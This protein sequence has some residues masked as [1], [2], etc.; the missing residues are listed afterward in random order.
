MDNKYLNISDKK[1]SSSWFEIMNN[2]DCDIIILL[3]LAIAGI[4]ILFLIYP[5]CESNVKNVSKN[6]ENMSTGDK[7][8]L[9]LITDK[10]S[11]AITT[12]LIESIVTP[13]MLADNLKTKIDKINCIA[14]YK[15]YYDQ[16]LKYPLADIFYYLGMLGDDPFEKDDKTK[17]FNQQYNAARKIADVFADVLSKQ[18]YKLYETYDNDGY[19]A[20]KFSKNMNDDL[21]IELNKIIN[22]IIENPNQ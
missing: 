22:K 13:C 8:T 21:S 5:R 2:S 3:I 12:P 18:L 17:R 19:N 7:S 15:H 20:D 1:Q 16:I 10:A 14:T 6:I 9:K 11:I 4:L